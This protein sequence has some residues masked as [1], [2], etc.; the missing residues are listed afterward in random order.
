MR[1]IGHRGCMLMLGW[2]VETSSTSAD[3]SRLPYYQLVLGRVSFG[4]GIAFLTYEAVIAE[5]Q[6]PARVTIATC[7]ILS[8]L[9][10]AFGLG[11]SERARAAW[12]GVLFAASSACVWRLLST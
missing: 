1:C 5:E 11:G 2:R 8:S 4:T 6:R 9:V 10:D 3:V 12:R 7:F